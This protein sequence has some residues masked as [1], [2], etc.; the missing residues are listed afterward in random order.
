MYGK[1][2]S[3][4]K[5]RHKPKCECLHTLRLWILMS[6]ILP[7]MFGW[8]LVWS[9]K[10]V[11]SRKS[12]HLVTCVAR[13]SLKAGE[14]VKFVRQTKGLHACSASFHCTHLVCQSTIS[15]AQSKSRMMCCAEHSFEFWRA[16]IVWQGQTFPDA[17]K[18]AK[19]FS[20]KNQIP[21]S[22][23]L[24]DFFAQIIAQ[25]LSL[26]PL[27]C[28]LVTAACH[29]ATFW[30]AFP[31]NHCTGQN[32]CGW[33]YL[34]DDSQDATGVPA[35]N[36]WRTIL[37]EFSHGFSIFNLAFFLLWLRTFVSGI[38]VFLWA[39]F[40][41]CCRFEM[42]HPW[43]WGRSFVDRRAGREWG[44]ICTAGG[45]CDTIWRQCSGKFGDPSPSLIPALFKSFQINHTASLLLSSKD[46][47]A[48]KQPRSHSLC[49]AMSRL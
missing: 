33:M 8:S 35:V 28:T 38:V 32:P 9:D 7:I 19:E 6:I 12:I 42:R 27:I 23:D 21:C 15:D 2:S 44:G 18:L 14:V 1:G 16:N 45:Q 36:A 43:I 24:K 31:S 26:S 13:T 49:T 37:L 25:V 47:A 22:D 10:N 30:R 41:R 34:C 48:I 5:R 3:S 29:A 46:L 4:R 17:N 11:C 39:K 40:R 20:S